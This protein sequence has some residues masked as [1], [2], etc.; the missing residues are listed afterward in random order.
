MIP[1]NLKHLLGIVGLLTISV[2]TEANGIVD[3]KSVGLNSAQVTYFNNN[4]Q[5]LNSS[6]LSHTNSSLSDAF[7]APIIH[8]VADRVADWQLA[9]FDIRSNKMRPEGRVSGHPAGW[10]YATLH[11][12]LLRWANT[13][14]DTS[15][16][17]AVI[18]LS[19]LNGYNLGPRI[20][21]ADDQAI[22]DVYLSLFSEF[23]GQEKITSTIEHLNEVVSHPSKR[24]LTFE[25]KNKE[26]H[27]GLFRK[28]YDPKCTSRWC[29]ADA[30]FMAPPV[31]AHLSKISGEPA[32]TQFMHKEFWQMTEYLFD[33]EYGLYLRDSRY[34]ER[35]DA[36]QRPIFW[37][38][39]NG[40][41]VAGIA[42]VL[43]YLPKDDVKRKQYETLFVRLCDSLIRYQNDDGSW[44]SSL[45]EHSSNG[46]SETSGTALIAFAIAWGI[47]NNI[48][49]DNAYRDAAIK[50]WQAIVGN[51]SANGKVGYV[52]QVAFAPGS[53]KK[54]DT[55]L[56]GSGAV[57]LAAAE[58]YPLSKK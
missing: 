17:Q 44:P 28:F 51:I 22:G 20:Y 56:Y 55:Q 46:H 15:L 43:E 57:L 12:G 37:G 18:N 1:S 27:Q 40:W 53:A 25:S 41:S 58:L 39:G 21:H 32:Y 31:F 6:E 26:I 9:Q 42:R 50:A 13:V 2:C 10:M 30:I 5:A 29:W 54:E 36:Q 24:S 35:K 11:I 19:A 45:L 8:K 52:Q 14:S 48:L 23:G 38:R 4:Y 16:K 34:F 3:N 7:E 47:N 49:T 33:E